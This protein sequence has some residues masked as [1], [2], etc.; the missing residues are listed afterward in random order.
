MQ[1]W[2]APGG[3]V[4]LCPTRLLLAP[5]QLHDHPSWGRQLPRD[6]GA[7]RV[8]RQASPQSSGLAEGERFHPPPYWKVVSVFFSN[9]NTSS[10]QQLQLKGL[11]VSTL[12]RS[13]KTETRPWSLVNFKWFYTYK[14]LRQC[15]TDL[16]FYNNSNKV[17]RTCGLFLTVLHWSKRN[18]MPS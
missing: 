9:V 4:S 16:W 12:L 13:L 15:H 14:R 18:S 11:E 2:W 17:T 10:A 3:F 7:Q 8:S 5:R 1:T 6:P